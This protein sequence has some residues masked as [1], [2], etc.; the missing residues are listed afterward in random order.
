V[1]D[2]QK[3]YGGR[4]RSRCLRMSPTMELACTLAEKYS[5]QNNIAFAPVKI[6]MESSIPCSKEATAPA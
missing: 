2:V 4:K 6:N 5:P 3:K 1:K